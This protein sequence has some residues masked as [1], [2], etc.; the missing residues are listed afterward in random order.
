MYLTISFL[1]SRKICDLF[2]TTV[3]QSR[4]LIRSVMSKYQYVLSSAIKTTITNTILGAVQAEA[5]DDFEFTVNSENVVEALNRVLAS[6]DGTLPQIAKKKGT[7]TT[8]ILK[9]S[10]RV[11]LFNIT[12][13][14]NRKLMGDLLASA[15][16]LLTLIGMLYSLW[17]PEIIYALELKV[18]THS[19]D[20]VQD[21]RGSYD[22][23]RSR[24]LPLAVA[25][26]TL[27]SVFTPN[28]IRIVVASFENLATSGWRSFLIIDLAAR[29]VSA[30][31][32]WVS[33]FLSPF[34][35]AHR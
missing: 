33:F 27:T 16:L 14:R 11:Y 31:N 35:C 19:A 22:I 28:L 29:V 34:N 1:T 13:S 7:V 5:G 17:Y 2:Q 18:K 24:A 21:H 3:S 8:Y 6:L 20:R 30:S 25:A 12:R 4:A 15:S 23:Y 10:S 26:V 32:G 9:P